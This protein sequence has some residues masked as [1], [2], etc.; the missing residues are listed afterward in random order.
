MTVSETIETGPFASVRLKRSFQWNSIN[1]HRSVSPE[2]QTKRIRSENLD[3]QKEDRTLSSLTVPA[4]QSVLLLH[5]KGHKY[6]L[7]R[8]YNVPDIKNDREL[9]I[10]IQYVGLN[11][12]DWKSA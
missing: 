8:G 6:T 1:G 2:P 11:P 10:R 3:F 4:Q 7:Q 5:G 9:L 12:I